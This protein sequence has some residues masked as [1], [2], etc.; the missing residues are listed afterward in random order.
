MES[1]ARDPTIRCEH[2]GR[3]LMESLEGRATV[4]CSRCH[5]VNVVS[6]FVGV[7]GKASEGSGEIDGSFRPCAQTAPDSFCTISPHR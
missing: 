6:R 2:C 7:Q 4:Q 5:T 1:P 3:K